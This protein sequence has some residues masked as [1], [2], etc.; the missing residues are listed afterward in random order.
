MTQSVGQWSPA[1][2]PY[3]I[4]VSEAQWWERTAQLA[5][6]RLGDPEDDRIAWFSSRQIDARQ[7]VVA[8]QQLLNAERLE[9]VALDELGMDQA[10]RDDL[11][12]ARQAFE[13]AL[14]GIKHMRDA[15]LHFDEWA[16]GEGRG[17]QKTRV[18][19][20]IPHREVASEFWGFEYDPAAAT[21]SLGPYTINVAVV[22]D[23]VVALA[24]AIYVA[25]H[26]VDTRNATHLYRQAVAALDAAGI[27]WNKEDAP[28]RVAFGRRDRRVWFSTSAETD[29]AESNRDL[30]RAVSDALMQA[31]LRLV[32]P[33]QA[34]D[35][36]SDLLPGWPLSCGRA[37]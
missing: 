28:L 8:L 22:E 31:G 34:G 9:Q 17:P 33:A 6:R 30:C 5:L 10:V 25:A 2:N 23:A 14:P 4:A 16:R 20:G 13:D 15:L 27:P 18:R 26:A 35:I 32:N 29:A 21:I 1:D 7:L 37:G 36:P 11:D 3:A 19:A 12:R 24:E